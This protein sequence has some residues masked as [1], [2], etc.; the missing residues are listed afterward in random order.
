MCIVEYLCYIEVDTKIPDLKEAIIRKIASILL[1]LCM[2]L[3]VSVGTMAFAASAKTTAKTYKVEVIDH[4]TRYPFDA[5][6]YKPVGVTPK[7]GVV[8]YAGY[9]VDY[10]DYGPLLKKI[11]SN[12][13]L[14]I[15]PEF[16]MDTAITNP[17]A[18]EEYMKQYPDIKTWF[19]AGHSHGGGTAC[20]E[21]SLK[22]ELFNGI[23]LIAGAPFA[24][25]LPDNYPVLTIHATEDLAVP[26]VQHKIQLMTIANCDVTDVYIKG[27]NHAQ[28]GDYGVQTPD[29]KATISAEKQVNITVKH[30]LKFINKYQ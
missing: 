30:I 5:V 15:S 16:P 25:M 3:A 12:G 10:R 13:Y 24:T 18:G 8:F 2:M 23:I 17:R 14:V 19:L 4:N 9:P 28:F 27:G 20:V 26:L 21:A 29:G 6:I 7:I 1:A 11:A 22:P